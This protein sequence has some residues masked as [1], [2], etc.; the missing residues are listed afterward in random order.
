MMRSQIHVDVTRSN[1]VR[2]CVETAISLRSRIDVLVNNAGVMLERYGRA[3]TSDDF[4]A[5]FEVN[6]VGVWHMTQVLLP[7]FTANGGGKVVIVA[8]NVGRTPYADTPAYSASKA[9]VINLTRSLAMKLGVDNINVNAICPG[10]VPTELTLAYRKDMPNVEEIV[11]AATARAALR[12]E[13]TARDIGCAAVF[14]ASPE[15]HNITGQ[16]LNVDAGF[17]MS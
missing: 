5:T 12:R 1:S 10:A 11:R 6:V 13:V 15:A 4:A 7:H 3:T 14:L 17:Q 16:A 2:T 9:A 8:C